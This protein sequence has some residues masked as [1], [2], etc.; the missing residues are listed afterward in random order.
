MKNSLS[1][2]EVLDTFNSVAPTLEQEIN[3]PVHLIHVIGSRWSYKA[4]R[5]PEDMPCVIAVRV[6]LTDDWALILYP[7]VGK[8]V[9]QDKVRALFLSPLP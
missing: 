3:G 8:E 1:E 4:G 9:H 6:V 5:I 7:S 2:K